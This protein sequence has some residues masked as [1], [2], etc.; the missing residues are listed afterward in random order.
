M[1]LQGEQVDSTSTGADL[2]DAE[3]DSLIDGNQSEG[4]REIPMKGE[5][6]AQAQT[7]QVFKIKVDGKEIEAPIEKLTQ[8]GQLGYK[9]SQNAQSLKQQQEAF[10]KQQQEW[11]QK[12]GDYENKYK[13]YQEI[14]EFAAKH[15]DWWNK[16]TKEYEQQI[17][18]AQS[19]GAS[20]P[21]IE[22]LKN[23]LSDFKKWRQ[24]LEAEK[25]AQMVQESDKTLAQEI[26][27]LRKTYSFIDFDSPDEN[28]NSLEQRVLEHGIGMGL[29]GSK[30][31]HF[32]AA[33]RDYYH[34]QLL[35]KAKEEGKEIVSK[36]R[37]K[38]TKLGI[39]GESSKPTKGLKVAS[40][41]QNKTYEDLMREALEEL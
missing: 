29:D 25:Q 17:K 26:D 5:A 15:P 13:P 27:S 21:E 1:S 24:S 11:Q 41:V 7:P 12:Y 6:Q 31:G 10:L 8:W 30:P 3:I 33:F 2:S 28:G 4:N 38:Q 37:Q 18:T 39:L 20:N 14:D 34:D 16:V 9:Y 40:D 32:R 19:E 36:E 23:E 22:A 35:G